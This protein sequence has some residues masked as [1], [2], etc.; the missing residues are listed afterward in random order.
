MAN[1]H[2]KGA[3]SD[4]LKRKRGAMADDATPTLDRG[5]SRK[6]RNAAKNAASVS[7]NKAAANTTGDTVQAIVT[8]SHLTITSLGTN[9][10]HNDKTGISDDTLSKPTLQTLPRELRDLIYD[11]VAATEERIVLGRRMTEARNKRYKTE[12]LY[13][14]FKGAIALHPLSM[15]C[16]QLLGEFQKVHVATSQARWTLVVN[17]FDL[18]QIKNFSDFIQSGQYI[19]VTGGSF[20]Q[21]KD[22]CEE[23]WIHQV[24]SYNFDVSL[25]FQMD[26]HGL[27]SAADLRRYLLRHAGE[28]P[29]SLANPNITKRWFGVADISTQ[30]VPRTSAPVDE[31]HS[32]TLEQAESIQSELY[33]VRETLF[34]V[35]DEL[36]MCGERDF[37]GEVVADSYGYM[38]WCWFEPFSDAYVRMLEADERMKQM[39]KVRRTQ[40][41]VE[42]SA[43]IFEHVH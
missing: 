38:Q 1:K 35:L 41:V 17:N 10:T 20:H 12:T 36:E 40:T 9:A 28:A 25:R 26:N 37:G 5:G 6:K 31:R 42:D 7:A 4:G 39:G 18:D 29:R 15:T 11:F 34:D 23:S 27:K 22:D 19:K 3:M 30:Y 24:P 21:K 32:M 8:R 2:G 13:E 14:S 16:H 33:D 43:K